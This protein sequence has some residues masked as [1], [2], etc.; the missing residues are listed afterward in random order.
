MVPTQP[1]ALTCPWAGWQPQLHPKGVGSALPTHHH[2]SAA[3]KGK[4][5][6][7]G[8]R[9]WTMKTLLHGAAVVTVVGTLLLRFQVKKGSG[10]RGKQSL[11]TPINSSAPEAPGLSVSGLS[12]HILGPPWTRCSPHPASGPQALSLPPTFPQSATFHGDQALG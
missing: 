3:S 8:G 11:A 4:A 1:Q 10:Q 7:D 6:Q 9:G 2:Q 12:P 5:G